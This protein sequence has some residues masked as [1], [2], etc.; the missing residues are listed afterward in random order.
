MSSLPVEK[1]SVPSGRSRSEYQI[2]ILQSGFGFME[3]HGEL[4]LLRP[5]TVVLIRPGASPVF[6]LLTE[7]VI[8]DFHFDAAI[9]GLMNSNAPVFAERNTLSLPVETVAE[10]RR[11]AD[12]IRLDLKR[13]EP[14]YQLAVLE[15][16]LE[17]D[18]LLYRDSR[19]VSRMENRIAW[20]LRFM[21]E[22]YSRDI[23]LHDLAGLIGVSISDYRRIFRRLLGTAPI[24]CLLDYRLRQSEKRLIQT[25]LSLAEIAAET[26]FNDPNYFSR[27]FARRHG[28]PPREWRKSF[29]KN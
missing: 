21:V 19:P 7:S 17:L 1:I 13:Q 24:D 6:E 28:L 5:G 9:A 29:R 27:V 22:N 26:G 4:F 15:K 18:R 11:L 8:Q 20:T 14:G 3:D 16:I 23:T 25:N 2:R 12:D 10:T